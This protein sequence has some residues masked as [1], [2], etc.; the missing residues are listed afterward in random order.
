MNKLISHIYLFITLV[1][2]I[3]CKSAQVDA[4][5]SWT[6]N[7][8][9]SIMRINVHTGLLQKI[10][11]NHIDSLDTYRLG[12]PEYSLRVEAAGHVFSIDGEMWGAFDGS[13]VVLIVDTVARTIER[14][15]KTKHTGYNFG[16]YQFVRKDTIFSFGGYGFWMRNNLM[17]YYSSVRKEWNLYTHAPFP[18]VLPPYEAEQHQLCFYDKKHDR[19]Y[20]TISDELYEYDFKLRRWSFTGYFKEEVEFNAMTM[21]HRISDSTLMLMGPKTALALDFFHN[22]ADNVTMVNKANV[23]NY[24]TMEFMRCAYEVAN[25]KVL[26]IPRKSMLLEQGYVFE[27]AALPMKVNGESLEMTSRWSKHQ[28]AWVLGISLGLFGLVLLFYGYRWYQNNSRKTSS[29]FSPKQQKVLKILVQDI[30]TT[31]SLNA[32]LQVEEKSWEVQRRERSMCIKDLNKIGLELFEEEIVLRKRA[33]HDKRQVEY[34]LN[35]KV[36]SDLARLMH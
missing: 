24:R 36:K 29:P 7:K 27:Y 6:N 32:I 4:F 18:I 25:S 12:Y 14:H 28:K 5:L 15:D 23:A 22:K 20:G 2:A 35:A 26:L 34:V 30:L 3:N 19:F 13:G 11:A 33:K 21:A 9:S 1:F 17:T 8:D 16:A 10:S 31:E